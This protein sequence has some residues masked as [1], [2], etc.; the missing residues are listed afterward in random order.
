MQETKVHV[1]GYSVDKSSMLLCG[2]ITCAAPWA[3]TIAGLDWTGLI[4]MKD[5]TDED[6][7]SANITK[8]TSAVSPSPSKVASQP[9][10]AAFLEFLEVKGHKSGCSQ[11]LVGA[12]HTLS[13]HLFA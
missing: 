13:A 11:I 4:P 8:T 5:G 1:Q 10:E 7:Q 6:I 2:T 3:Y 12:Q 9:T